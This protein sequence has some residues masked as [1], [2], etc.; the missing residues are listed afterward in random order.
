[1]RVYKCR[2]CNTISSFDKSVGYPACPKCLFQFGY[3]QDSDICQIPVDWQ[4]VR[5]RLEDRLR[6]DEAAVQQCA[7]FLNVNLA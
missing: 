7:A 1:M 2:L 3:N 5:R 4:K 6:K